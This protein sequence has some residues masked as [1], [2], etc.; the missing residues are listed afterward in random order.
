MVQVCNMTVSLR[1]AD[2]FVVRYFLIS[3]ARSACRELISETSP[4]VHRIC[5]SCRG[6]KLHARFIGISCRLLCLLLG[7]LLSEYK[8]KSKSYVDILLVRNFFN[9]AFMLPRYVFFK[10]TCDPEC[11]LH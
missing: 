1:P 5:G 9:I 6:K 10:L 7:F 2:V 8:E 11:W 4:S 3:T